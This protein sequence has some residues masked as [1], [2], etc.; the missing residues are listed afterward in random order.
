MKVWCT[1]TLLHFVFFTSIKTPS[2]STLYQALITYKNLIRKIVR[3]IT[4]VNHFVNISTWVISICF[5]LLSQV[6]KNEKGNNIL[7]IQSFM[8]Y[9]LN[10][11]GATHTTHILPYVPH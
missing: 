11:V 6:E 7:D 2:T 5:N 8:L 9:K 4:R 3:D 1:E 10:I